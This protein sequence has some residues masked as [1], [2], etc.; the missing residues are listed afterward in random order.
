[1]E[2]T[3]GKDVGEKNQQRPGEKK[4]PLGKHKGT[5]DGARTKKVRWTGRKKNGNE[6]KPKGPYVLATASA[7]NKTG[8]QAPDT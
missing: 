8:C 3:T 5:W 2:G 7:K 1:M 6:D 4:S